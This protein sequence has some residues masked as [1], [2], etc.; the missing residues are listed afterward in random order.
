MKPI[1]GILL[2]Q[3]VSFWPVWVWYA[4]RLSDGSD[5]PWGILAL[6][7][8]VSIGAVKGRWQTPPASSIQWSALLVGVYAAAY[9]WLPYLGRGLFCVLALT[10]IASPALFGKRIQ[11][12][13]TG[14]LVLS[15]PL[16]ASLQFYGG[17]PIRLVTAYLS[18]W[19]LNG[20]GYPIEVQGTLLHWFGEVIAVDAPCAGI[21]MLWSG[22]LVN[23][24][25]AAWFDLNLLKTWIV[26]SFT[27]AS[28]FTGNVLRATALF[29]IE[30]GILKSPAWAH[31]TVGVII[32]L[33]V[34]TAI[35]M[36][37]SRMN[38]G[39]RACAA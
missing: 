10:C 26:T 24:C 36:I 31:Q 39:Y 8:A 12:G 19:L 4:K 7:A 15:L 33:V 11:P 14:L 23:F 5:E 25:L 18:A 28:V 32:F 16:I 21:R 30:S 13:I 27:M 3:T 6:L 20:F 35:L 9:A 2:L 38:G 22:L 17:F 29:F 34:V 1:G 37:H